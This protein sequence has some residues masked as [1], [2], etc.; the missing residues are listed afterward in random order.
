M[1]NLIYRT[2][3]HPPRWDDHVYAHPWSLAVS[4]AAIGIGVQ[5]IIAIVTD[6]RLSRVAEI[7]PT[8]VL[9]LLAAS[10][11]LG[12]AMFIAGTFAHLKT[13]A[14]SEFL[15]RIGM[16]GMA[17]GWAVRAL[18]LIAHTGVADLTSV[19]TS[20]CLCIG[21]LISLIASF[22]N[23]KS[24]VADVKYLRRRGHLDD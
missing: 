22:K 10:L 1:P 17:T 9:G 14:S 11:I 24:L 18:A 12:G 8:P 21:A 2:S 3:H 19:W 6:V 7:L 16:L 15:V 20:V 23:G 5:M 13:L 4:F